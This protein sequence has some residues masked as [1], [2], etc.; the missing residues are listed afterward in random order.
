MTFRCGLLDTFGQL[1]LANSTCNSSTQHSFPI[2]AD[3]KPFGKK[4]LVSVRVDYDECQNLSSTSPVSGIQDMISV[5]S[6]ARED[7]IILYSFMIHVHFVHVS[8]CLTH[9]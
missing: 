3:K 5:N 4:Y 2:T 8:Q 6:N 1:T 9:Q 7:I